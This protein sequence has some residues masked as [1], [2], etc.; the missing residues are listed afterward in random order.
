MKRITYKIIITIILTV[1]TTFLSWSQIYVD[2]LLPGGSLYDLGRSA[3][4]ITHLRF[5]GELLTQQQYMLQEAH[6]STYVMRLSG[7][8]SLQGPRRMTIHGNLYSRHHGFQNNVYAGTGITLTF[9]IGNRISILGN[10]SYDL[11]YRSYRYKD[12]I[13]EHPDYEQ[14]RPESFCHTPSIELGSVFLVNERMKAGVIITGNVSLPDKEFSSGAGLFLR[15]VNDRQ[16]PGYSAS[17]IDAYLQYRYYSMYGTGHTV[18]AGIQGSLLRMTGRLFYRASSD[19]QCVGIGIGFLPTAGLDIHY[20]FLA[21][22][23][24]SGIMAGVAAHQLGISYRL[25]PQKNR[26]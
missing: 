3:S 12:V 25:S 18:S 19:I 15:Y 23:R 13:T 24:F 17:S 9:P 22:F 10:M 2:P 26:L 21:P 5:D 16:R 20:T 7:S 11:G 14:V 8:P 6:P 1:S 4:A